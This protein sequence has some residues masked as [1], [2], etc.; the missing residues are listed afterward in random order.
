MEIVEERK[1]RNS[2]KMGNFLGEKKLLAE[3]NVNMH[4]S[5]IFFF[6]PLLER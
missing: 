2:W 4:K 1:E 3:F 6:S 5:S